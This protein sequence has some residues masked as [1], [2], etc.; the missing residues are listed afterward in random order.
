MTRT[1]RIDFLGAPMP[2][3][4]AFALLDH[5]LDLFLTKPHLFVCLDVDQ[6]HIDLVEYGALSLDRVHD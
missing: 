3:P 2:L 4:A 6:F 1:P 5:F